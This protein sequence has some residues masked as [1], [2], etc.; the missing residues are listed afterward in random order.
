M[1]EH[2]SCRFPRIAKTRIQPTEEDYICAVAAESSF[3]SFSSSPLS[4]VAKRNGRN[5]HLFNIE[6]FDLPRATCT[7]LFSC[8]A[9]PSTST[10]NTGFFVTT[11]ITTKSTDEARW[12][13]A[14]SWW[15]S[16]IPGGYSSYRGTGYDSHAIGP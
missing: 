12:M 13:N 1:Y 15:L 14:S 7:G 3:R 5:P 16:A 4:F 6:S 2:V 8:Q 10:T 9:K 11:L